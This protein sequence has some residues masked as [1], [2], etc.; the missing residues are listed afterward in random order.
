MDAIEHFEGQKHSW[1]NTLCYPELFMARIPFL[2]PVPTAVARMTNVFTL[3]LNPSG[4]VDGNIFWFSFCPEIMFDGPLTIAYPFAY[5]VNSTA[6]DQSGVLTD[7]K[8]REELFPAFSFANVSNG[9][10]VGASIK[11]SQSQPL[12]HRAGY[13]ACSRVYGYN[14]DGLAMEVSKTAVL[15]SV[16]Q[17]Q[18]NYTNGETLRMVYAPGDFS[19]LHMSNQHVMTQDNDR[20]SFPNLMGFVE[21]INLGGNAVQLT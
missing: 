13:G 3:T 5:S 21:G 11:I 10:I 7:H 1:A 18:A 4:T 20:S 6:N 8:T 14:A 12:V 16:Y 19:D 2:C 9:R 15:S 17:D